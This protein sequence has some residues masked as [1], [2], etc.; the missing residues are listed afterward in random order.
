MYNG[1]IDRSNF[2]NDRRNTT[3]APE[4]TV[5]IENDDGEIVEFEIPTRWE[6]CELCDGEGTHVN[7]SI[8]AGG[9]S[10]EAFLEDPDFYEDYMGGSYDVAC[11]CCGGSGKVKMPNL[12]M[13]SDELR[14]AYAEQQAD[15][16]AY[17]AECRAERIMGA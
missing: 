16:A 8:D 7:P 2:Y 11:H 17:E 1:Y 4:T 6:I 15:L 13:L 12:D 5:S 10:A 3:H 14:A 9:I